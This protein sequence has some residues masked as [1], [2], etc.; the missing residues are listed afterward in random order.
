MK[1]TSV[2]IIVGTTNEKESL[3]TTVNTIMDTCNADDID[4]ILLVK[5]K[6]ASDNC[7]SAIALL[8]EKY[9][10]KVY[11]LEQ[12]R[13]FVGGAIRDGFDTVTSSHTMLLPSDLAISLDCVSRMIQAVKE[14]PEVISKTS[15]W[16]NKDSFHDYNPSRKVLNRAAQIFLRIL[17]S[18]RL[19]DFTS[20]V[21]TAPT[22]AYRESAWQE[23]NFPFLLE[24][25]LVPLRLGY[26][27]E[28]IPVSCHEREEGFSRNSA[29]QTA[30][31]LKT[32]LRV[33]FTKKSKLT[34]ES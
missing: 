24:M 22:Q 26:R 5:S 30:L 20:P 31:Y 34:K 14:K 4:K 27:F 3:I 19:T 18:T 25:V 6:D 12:T 32:A 7:N 11:S 17:Y 28:E 21:Q 16:L 15:R 23:L 10:G 29:L 33:R 9:Q 8:E 1:F 2:T 13:P